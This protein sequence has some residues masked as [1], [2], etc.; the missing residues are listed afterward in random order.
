MRCAEAEELI[1]ES[2]DAPLDAES[3]RALA[4]HLTQ[5]ASCREFQR[6]QRELDVSL[7][8]FHKAPALSPGF[9]AELRRR[10][11]AE[12]RGALLEYLP[13]LLHLGGG[14]GTSLVCVWLLP[15]SREAVLMVGAV[16]TVSAYL[17]LAFLRNLFDDV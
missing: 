3:T 17:V 7:A 8:R 11:A 14:L 6:T 9:E 5:C 16:S 10:V 13:D 12:R 15:F 1:L 4:D 2:L